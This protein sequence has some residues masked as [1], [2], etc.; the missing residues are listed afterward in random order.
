MMTVIMKTFSK[1]FMSKAAGDPDIPEPSSA[2]MKELT[3]ELINEN[4]FT[5][6]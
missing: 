2:E 1:P 6:K 3:V 5:Q 4:E